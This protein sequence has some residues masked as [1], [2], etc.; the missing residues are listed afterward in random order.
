[1]AGARV[2]GR[3]VIVAHNGVGSCLELSE[4][5]VEKVAWIS[6]PWM[7]RLSNEATAFSASRKS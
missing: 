4:I 6:R 1:M 3:A 2:S 5:E 7:I